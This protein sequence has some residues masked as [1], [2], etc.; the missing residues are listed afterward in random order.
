MGIDFIENSVIKVEYLTDA[1]RIFGLALKGKNNILADIRDFPPVPT[2]HGNFEF[3][4]GHRLWHSP[5]SMPRT[6]IPDECDLKVH[7]TELGVILE[8]PF[9]PITKIRK[10]I[11]VRLD[12]DRPKLELI[13]S[14]TNEGIWPVELA[15]WAITQFKPNG[16]VIMP[17]PGRME[18]SLLPNRQISFWPYSR[19]ADPRLRL[20]DDY[21]LFRGTDDPAPFKMGYFNPDGW[22]GYVVDGLFFKKSFGAN[23]SLEFPDLG[24]NAEVYGV[25][26]FVELESLAPLHVLQPS[27][28]ITHTEV[29]EVFEDLSTLPPH[30]QDLLAKIIDDSMD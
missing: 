6:Y 2:M 10:K 21:C 13:H 22:L 20:G 1:L 3:R 23:P 9:E 24:C 18:S 7:K 29:W 30:L 26:R 16:V 17:M 19:L 15:P 25:D 27:G 8:T 11:E 5:E 4:G 12:Q 28:S 14:L